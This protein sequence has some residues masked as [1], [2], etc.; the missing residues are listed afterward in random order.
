MMKIQTPEIIPNAVGDGPDV[1]DS[2]LADVAVGL[3][4]DCV[5][6]GEVSVEVETSV[7]D[8]MAF[9]LDV[10]TKDPEDA[11]TVEVD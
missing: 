5:L 3:L 8:V 11:A 7:V 10:T 2:K 4:D 6:A 9:T 1:L